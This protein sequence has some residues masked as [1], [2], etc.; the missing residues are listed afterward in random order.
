MKDY[1]DL[2]EPIKFL[3]ERAAKN[4]SELIDARVYNVIEKKF[5]EYDLKDT[6]KNKNND[7][8]LY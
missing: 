7:D 8:L 1:D 5:I 2:F 3:S 4:E 6:S